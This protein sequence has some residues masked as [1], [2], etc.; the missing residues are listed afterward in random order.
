MKKLQNNIKILAQTHIHTLY[1]AHALS[2]VGEIINKA[3]EDGLELVALTDHGPKMPDSGHEWYF[4][5]VGALPHMVSGIYVLKGAEANI[6][7]YKG[8]LDLAD[9]CLKNLDFNIASV[10]PTSTLP[11]SD[12]DDDHTNAYLGAIENP[13]IDVIG[14]SGWASFRFDIDRVLKAAKEHNKLIEINNQSFLIRSE[15]I[16]ICKTIAKKC[17]EMGIGVVV[18]ADAHSAYMLTAV[19]KALNLLDEIDFPE[20]L[21]MNTTAKKLL[22]FVTN[23]RGITIDEYLK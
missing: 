3:K 9:K 18:G 11:P 5:N 16:P 1:S 14:H 4:Q 12:N 15:S 13:Y 8:T 2:T 20:V 17:A 19:Q 21:I 7:D 23:R 6:I 22:N 10:H